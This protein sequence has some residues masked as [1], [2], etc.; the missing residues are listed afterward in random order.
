M[1]QKQRQDEKRKIQE[2]IYLSKREEAKQSKAVKVQLEH[3]R[4]QIEQKTEQD[5]KMKN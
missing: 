2:A 4:Q 1:L 3:R 5:N